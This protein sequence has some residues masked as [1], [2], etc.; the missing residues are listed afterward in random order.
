MPTSGE[1]SGSGFPKQPEPRVVHEASFTLG[2]VP[3]AEPPWEDWNPPP[4]GVTAEEWANPDFRDGWWHAMD[5][6]DA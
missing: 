4:E 5:A 1:H 3:P 2:P 6:P